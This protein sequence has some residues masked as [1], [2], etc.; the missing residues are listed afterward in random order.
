[1]RSNKTT[2]MSNVSNSVRLHI[3]HNQDL[4]Y[5]SEKKVLIIKIKTV[6]YT[7]LQVREEQYHD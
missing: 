4:G 6:R 5:Y 2:L 7:W 3:V 1:M